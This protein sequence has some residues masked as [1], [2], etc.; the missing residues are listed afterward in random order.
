MDKVKMG[1]KVFT[2]HGRGTVLAI[3]QDGRYVVEFE[4]GGASFLYPSQIRTIQ[5]G[6]VRRREEKC[7]PYLQIS[8]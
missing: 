6:D 7:L 5:Y 8:S 4:E 1:Q 3:L 2:E